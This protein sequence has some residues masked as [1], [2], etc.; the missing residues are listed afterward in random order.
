MNVETRRE[1][2]FQAAMACARKGWKYIQKMSGLILPTGKVQ[3]SRWSSTDSHQSW[4]PGYKKS[5]KL[6]SPEGHF[7]VMWHKVQSSGEFWGYVSLRH[8][9]ARGKVLSRS[10]F[11]HEV[12][13]GV[14]LSL[15]GAPHPRWFP[16]GKSWALSIDLTPWNKPETGDYRGNARGSP[17]NSQIQNQIWKYSNRTSSLCLLKMPMG[18]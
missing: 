17:S 10:D 4:C 6:P 7:S 8:T 18:S 16:L 2:V 15:D 1:R 5:F 9:A 14:W 11:C 3:P 12:K 13:M